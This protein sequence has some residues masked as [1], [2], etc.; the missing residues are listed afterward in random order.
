MVSLCKERIW[1]AWIV[2]KQSMKIVY[3][4]KKKKGPVFGYKWHKILHKS[5]LIMS[6]QTSAYMSCIRGTYKQV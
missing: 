6:L 1:S 2:V 5:R 4:S 3:K